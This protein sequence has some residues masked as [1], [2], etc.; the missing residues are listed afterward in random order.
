MFDDI[1][2][3]AVVPA[4]GG[5]KGIPRKN[6]V[7]VGGQSLVEAA[8]ITAL[9]LS[10]ADVVILS[11]DDPEASDI[12]ERLGVQVVDR[13]AALATD[14]AS[15]VDVWRHAWLEAED[16]A[17][18]RFEISVLLQPTSPLRTGEDVTSTIRALVDGGYE[19]VTTVSRTPGHF[20]PEKLMV[21]TGDGLRPYLGDG[22][23]STRQQIPRYYY[24]NGYC[25]AAVRH[26]VIEEQ[27]VIGPG[28]GAHV[29]DRPVV[30]IDD[31]FDLE[32]ARWMS[33]RS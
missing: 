3:I 5:S 6:L 9:N 17:Q 4:R 8:L 27:R 20:T 26:R 33:G 15:N 29:I 21:A 13:P 23:V 10:W 30:N 12:G 2:T 19:A 25:Y 31:P 11:T 22:F 32:I 1:A 28:L 18:T 24:L 7:H 14:S 16:R